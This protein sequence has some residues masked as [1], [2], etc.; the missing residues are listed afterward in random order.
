[1]SA[2]RLA[3]ISVGIGLLGLSALAFATST[4]LAFQADKPAVNGAWSGT[5]T[6]KKGAEAHEDYIHLVLKQDDAVVTGTAGPDADRQYPIRKG[7]VTTTDRVAIAF[8]VIVNGEHM[9]F[10]LKLDRL[11]GGRLTGEAK[12]EGED[13]RPHTA[14]VDLKPVK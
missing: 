5:L 3:G 14:L 10:D 7:K 8:E 9:V 2:R 11:N 4:I 13:G 6:T 1:M 12:I